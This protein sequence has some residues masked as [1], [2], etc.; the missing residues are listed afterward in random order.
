MSERK[1][2][3]NDLVLVV[4]D[5]CADPYWGLVTMEYPS[6]ESLGIQT[7]EPKKEKII[8]KRTDLV[9]A[10]ETDGTFTSALDAFNHYLPRIIAKL[11]IFYTAGKELRAL[12]RLK[13]RL[14]KRRNKGFWGGPSGLD[15]IIYISYNTNRRPP[16]GGR[17][18]K[19]RR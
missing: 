18:R 11:A 6:G 4:D 14:V 7:D 13:E 1:I 19:E 3:K 15:I 12:K 17:K 8:R 5:D 2:G 10:V 9:F 16:G